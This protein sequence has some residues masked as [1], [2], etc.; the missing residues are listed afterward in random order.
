MVDRQK[1]LLGLIESAMG[2]LAYSG[3]YTEEGEEIEH[4]ENVT[5]LDGN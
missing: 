1:Q 2:K 3:L 5:A 4:D